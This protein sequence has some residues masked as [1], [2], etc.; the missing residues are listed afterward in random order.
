VVTW[1]RLEQATSLTGKIG[2]EAGFLSRAFSRNRLRT[3]R[4]S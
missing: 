4:E 2:E 1:Q 3:R